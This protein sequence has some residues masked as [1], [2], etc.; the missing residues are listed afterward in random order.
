MSIKDGELIIKGKE[1]MYRVGCVSIWIN[2]DLDGGFL[3]RR[4]TICGYNYD[5]FNFYV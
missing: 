4:I 3:E 5:D 1:S 2:G